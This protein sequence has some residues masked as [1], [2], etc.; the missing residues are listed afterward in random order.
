MKRR[1]AFIFWVKH[2][3]KKISPSTESQLAQLMLSLEAPKQGLLET[4]VT[5]DRGGSSR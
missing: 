5:S 1:Q 2:V 3:L 4:G